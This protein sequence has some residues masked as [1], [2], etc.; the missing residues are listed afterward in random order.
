[1]LLCFWWCVPK[2][3]IDLELWVERE[4]KERKQDL[5]YNELWNESIGDKLKFVFSPDVILCGSLG[6]KHQLTY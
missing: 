1:M 3:W 2:L 6:S 4:K 5:W